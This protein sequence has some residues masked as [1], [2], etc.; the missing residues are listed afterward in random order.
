VDF[1]Q[2]IYVDIPKSKKEIFETFLPAQ[3]F[4]KI[5]PGIILIREKCV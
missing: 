4:T 5:G 3:K 1:F 2:E